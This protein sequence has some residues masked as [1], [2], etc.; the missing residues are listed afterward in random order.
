[1]N[2]RRLFLLFPAGLLLALLLA[3]CGEQET[4][5]IPTPLPTVE[6]TPINPDAGPVITPTAVRDAFFTALEEG[7]AAGRRGE[8]DTALSQLNAALTLAQQENDRIGLSNVYRQIGIVYHTQRQYELALENYEL[9]AGVARELHNSSL[10]GNAL[11]NSGIVYF[12]QGDY[13]RALEFYNQALAV[14]Q[15]PDAREKDPALEGDVLFSIGKAYHLG[16]ELA[17]ALERYN[18]ALAVYERIGNQ[19]LRAN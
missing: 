17:L 10:E 16:G 12:D 5:V 4:A 7:I 18:G 13:T 2:V 19:V 14:A 11:R 3:A 9:A 1:M 8:Y 6:A 15:Q